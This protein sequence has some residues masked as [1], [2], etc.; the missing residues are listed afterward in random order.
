MEERRPGGIK[1][2]GDRIRGVGWRLER[3]AHSD[4][5]Q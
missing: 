1:L 2:M 3:L 4:G 5:D